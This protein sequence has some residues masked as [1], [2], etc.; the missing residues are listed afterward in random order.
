MS[1]TEP[2]TWITGEVLSKA[3]LDT[4]VRDNLNYLK[5]NIAL[6]AAAELTIAAGLVTK[7]RAHH[8]VDTETDAATDDLVTINGGGEGE[9][10]LIRPSSGAR[11]IVL[12]HNT[13][14]IWSPHGMD[15][16]LVDADSYALLAYSG[17]KWCI[18]G[19]G[20]GAFINLNDVPS[21][22]AG[23]GSKIVAVKADVTGLEFIDHVLT[24]LH[25]GPASYDDAGG[26]TVKVN[27]G[28]DGFEFA[29]P[30]FI[31]MSDVPSTY[32]GAS[33]KA[34]KVTS[35]EMALEFGSVGI[36]RLASEPAL[37]LSK[38][39][40]NTTNHKLYYCKEDV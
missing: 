37:E 26:K 38:L 30:T 34:V 35:D 40:H 33:G 4:Q 31:G 19:A 14:N 25:D 12:K 27:A 1:W 24:G 20:G 16:S 18:I 17:S 3:N 13:G 8:T 36:E 6:E 5:M 23:Q 2:R 15:L 10:L 21:A 9:I 39:Y 32:A 7:T 22:Y 28:A 29:I 11:T